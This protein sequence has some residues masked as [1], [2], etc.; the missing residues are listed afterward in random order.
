MEN[1]NE[2]LVAWC[3]ACELLITRYYN[4]HFHS[5]NPPRLVAVEGKRYVKIISELA[6]GVSKSA[7]AFVD[8][9]TGDILKPASWSAPAKHARGNIGDEH[10][11][12]RFIGPYGPAYLRRS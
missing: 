1:F 6:S 4:N 11:G 9:T 5:I 2:K 8:K 3:T 12:L 10:N 7:W